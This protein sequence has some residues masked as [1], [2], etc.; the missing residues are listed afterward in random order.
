MKRLHRSHAYSNPPRYEMSIK[1]KTS[2]IPWE[3]ELKVRQIGKRGKLGN[4]QFCLNY[5]NSPIWIPLINKSFYKYHIFWN[6]FNFK[7]FKSKSEGLE[8]KIKPYFLGNIVL[9]NIVQSGILMC[10][11]VWRWSRD[12]KLEA[13]PKITIGFALVEYL[14]HECREFKFSGSKPLIYIIAWLEFKSITQ[15]SPIIFYITCLF[16]QTKNH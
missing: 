10:S 5:E 7:C 3:N 6:D 4:F 16:F 8:T 2:W 14:N 12:W 13:L 9:D 1:Q 15:F 11:V